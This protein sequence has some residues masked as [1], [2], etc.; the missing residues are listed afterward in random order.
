MT[1]ARETGTELAVRSGGHSRAGHG[2]SDGGIVVDLSAMNVVEIDAERRT[3]W[4]QAGAT[5][6]DYTT[7]TAEHGLATGFGDTPS[8]GVGGITLSGGIGYLVRKNGLAID[9]LL[10]AEVV[11]ADG[12]LLD[13]DEESHADLFWAL[14]GGGGNVGLAT[15]LRFRLH[16]LDQ[17]VGGMLILPAGADV[18]AGLAAAAEAAPEELSVIANILKAPPLPFIPS[19]QHGKPI[20][21][22]LMVYAGDAEAGERAIAPIR[23]LATRLPTWCA[24]SATRRCSRGRNLRP[25]RSPRG[26]T[27]S[28]MRLQP[29]LLR[30]SSSTSRPPP[31]RWPQSSCASSAARW[32]ASPPTRRRSATAARS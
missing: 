20:V 22:A 30:R 14:R 18:I 2:T 25:P 23:A 27:S 24:R 3:A 11:T 9:D 1:L 7:T 29:E 28:S 6:G 26:R 8:G 21:I 16:E 17:V 5:T 19:E 12:E 32:R 15:R 10:E 31:P 13:V 4:A